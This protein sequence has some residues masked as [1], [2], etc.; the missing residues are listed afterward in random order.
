MNISNKQKPLT[1]L[2]SNKKCSYA[3]LLS[4]V[5]PMK[6]VT[7]DKV[8]TL[9]GC[10]VIGV[11]PIAYFNKNRVHSRIDIDR[12]NGDIHIWNSKYE[13]NIPDIVIQN[14]II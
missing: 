12:E 11:S 10:D 14:V 7:T 1:I 2:E 6:T 13:P 5:K 8:I 4:F 3:D 9:F